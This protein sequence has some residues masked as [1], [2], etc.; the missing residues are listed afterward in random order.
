MRSNIVL[1][2]FM[3]VTSTALANDPVTKPI[4]PVPSKDEVTSSQKEESK[5]TKEAAPIRESKA[6]EAAR[7]KEAQAADELAAKIA[8]RLAVIR[9]DKDESNKP[10]AR[11]YVRTYSVPI[12]KSAEIEQKPKKSEK[13]QSAHWSYEGEEGPLSWGKLNS[14]NVKCDLG[15][16]Q[17]PIDIRDGIKVD[18]DVLNFD[19]KPSQFQVLD[20]GH[21]IQVN[22]NPGNYVNVSG[23]AYELQ[24]FHFHRPSEE[25]I[26]GK[27]YEM[28]VHFVHR[29]RESKLAVVAI[30]LELGETHPG[31]QLVWN[32]LP[33]EKHEP[34]KALKNIDLMQF[35][36]KQ[37]GYF[38]YMGSL[39]T[40]PCSEGVLWLVMKEPVQLSPDQASIF[41]RL[42]PN[43]ARPIQKSAGRL[44]KESL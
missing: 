26:N 35:L 44:I 11:P 40:P 33:L 6:A 39:T 21:T 43:N 28:V 12:K 19:Y 18:L 14:A 30:L 3:I 27:G 23:K 38:T 37:R 34:I 41:A 29:D 36:P 2:A 8:E 42:Y 22:V 1:L 16:R 32:N 20:N 10:I 17:S 25:R 7:K 5:A 4:K 24:Q 9:K 15:E 31:V 13:S